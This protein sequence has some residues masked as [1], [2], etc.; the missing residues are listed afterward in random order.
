VEADTG[1]LFAPVAGRQFDLILSN[2]P[3]VI[4]P[5][6]SA[7]FRDN[8]F[9]LDG[10]LKQIVSDVPQ[11]LSRGGFFQTTCEWVETRGQD[12]RKR[13]EQWVD[14]CGCDAWVLQANRQFPESYSRDRLREMTADAEEL[15]AGLEVW[16]RYFEERQVEAVYGGLLFLRRR[17]GENWFDVTEISR[18]A[19]K[20]I[21]ESIV[22][23]FASRDLFFSSDGDRAMLAC[24]LCVAAGLRQEEVSRWDAGAWQVESIALRVDEGVP[25][26]IGIDHHLRDLI[27]LFDGKRDTQS[28]LNEFAEK[29]TM[30]ADVAQLRS[31]PMVRQF[32]RT[33]VLVPVI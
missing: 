10:F 25:V 11:Y 21:G 30:P 33:G 2:P 4:S 20:P 32:L 9:E 31:L 22:Q 28:V 3:F 16:M 1:D 27:G 8:P 15:A 12:W 24:R 7:T 5:S 14:Q 19:A 23:G 13:L 26:T 29:L 6:E 18:G 17:D